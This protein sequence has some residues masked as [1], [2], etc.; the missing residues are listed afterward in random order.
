MEKVTYRNK[1]KFTIIARAISGE[2]LLMKKNHC[3][4]SEM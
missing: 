3:Y 2:I 4:T 1:E